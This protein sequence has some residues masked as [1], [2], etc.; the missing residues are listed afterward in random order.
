MLGRLYNPETDREAAHRIWYECHW[1]NSKE[2]EKNMDLFLAAG[3]IHVAEFNGEA[4]CLVASVP[5]TVQYLEED[6]RLSVIT[7]VTTSR[8]VRKQG[9][10]GRLTAEVIAAAVEEGAQVSALSMFEQGFYDRLGFGT[11]GYEHMIRFDP[12]DLNIEAVFRPPRRLTKDDWQMIH[13]GMMARRR[14]HG[15]CNLNS[16][17]LIQA[18]LGWDEEGFGLGYCDGPNGELTH[19]FWA[20]G[21]EEFGPYYLKYLAYQTFGQLMELLAVIKSLGDQIRLIGITEPAEIQFQDLVRQPF[22]GRT[23]TA[24]T[25]YEQ[26]LR[27]NAYWQMRICDLPACMAKTHLTGD[28]VRC[29]VNLSDPIETLLDSETPWHGISGDYVVTLG[30]DSHAEEG[31]D[32]QLPTLNASVGAFTRMWLGVR[33][34]TGLA[35]TDDLDAPE[36][37]LKDLDRILHLP[38]ARVGWDY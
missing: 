33:P 25:Q 22:R 11:G 34:A 37:L 31:K 30:P 1:I 38:P 14:G 7:G 29:N 13:A 35:A 28:P 15:G 4:E 19:F 5:G 10:A 17:E 18:E 9:L 24:K 2:Q 36:L 26:H 27:A 3:R 32:P 20:Y 21:K 8:V 12:A 6:L 23:V 16:P